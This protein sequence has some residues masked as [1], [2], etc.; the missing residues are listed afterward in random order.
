MLRRFLAA[1]DEANCCP[2]SEASAEIV[3]LLVSLRKGTSSFLRNTTMLRIPPYLVGIFAKRTSSLVEV[4]NFIIR[5]VERSSGNST[6]SSGARRL[7]SFFV[8]DEI[9]VGICNKEAEVDQKDMEA[10]ICLRQDIVDGSSDDLGVKLSD[11]YF[12]GKHPCRS[13]Q[14]LDRAMVIEM[15][16]RGGMSADEPGSTDWIQVDTKEVP[17]QENI[18]KT[19]QVGV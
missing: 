10:W 18:P 6:E 9:M 7:D 4:A 1:V 19:W 11:D 15:N 16:R 3:G 8:L 12:E 2:P 14:S 17:P 5:H 13:L